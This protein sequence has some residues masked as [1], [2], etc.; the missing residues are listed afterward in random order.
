MSTVNNFER[1]LLLTDE[2]SSSDDESDNRPSNISSQTSSG[3]TSTIPD[4]KEAPGCTIDMT[5]KSP[6]E[7]FQLLVTDDILEVIVQQ[8]NLFAD[9]FLQDATLGPRSRVQAWERVTHNSDELKTFLGLVII[10]GL[11]NSHRSRCTGRQVGLIATWH[12]TRS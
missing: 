10:M 2:S 5:N 11:V 7:F 4:F 6:V 8:T 9:Q 12:S 3:A 1:N